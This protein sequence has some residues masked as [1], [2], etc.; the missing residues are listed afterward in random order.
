[1]TTVDGFFL[2][3]E[4]RTPRVQP[5]FAT[6]VSKE[7]DSVPVNVPVGIIVGP[8]GP[9]IAQT[10]RAPILGEIRIGRGFAAWGRTHPK[11]SASASFA[12]RAPEGL[13]ECIAIGRASEL[14]DHPGPRPIHRMAPGGAGV[15]RS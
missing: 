5:G 2:E 15:W 9:K 7:T 4:F 12:T 8:T 14:F 6:A 11:S 10:L 3:I 13:R 1:M